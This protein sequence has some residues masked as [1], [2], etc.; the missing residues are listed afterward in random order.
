MCLQE[1]FL[2][3]KDFS[4]ASVPFLFGGMSFVEELNLFLFLIKLEE[5]N[6]RWI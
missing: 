6:C 1:F 4:E 3:F 2:H 5:P